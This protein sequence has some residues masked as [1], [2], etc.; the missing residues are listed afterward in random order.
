MLLFVLN[1]ICLI[2]TCPSHS[3]ACSGWSSSTGSAVRKSTQP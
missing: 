1:I 3:V 2:F